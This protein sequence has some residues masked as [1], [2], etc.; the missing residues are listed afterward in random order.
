MDTD[1]RQGTAPSQKRFPLYL[2]ASLLSSTS[3]KT[4]QERE[5]FAFLTAKIRVSL[6]V[7]PSVALC[8]P[9]TRYVNMKCM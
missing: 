9:L 4:N 2:S 1:K 6:D 8:R 3:S 7:V 5:C